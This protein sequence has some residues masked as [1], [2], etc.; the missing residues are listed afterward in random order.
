[1]LL[2]GKTTKGYAAK[3]HYLKQT[4]KIDVE[5]EKAT[6]EMEPPKEEES[7]D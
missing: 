7:A 6:T 1:L 4:P 3:G 5:Q 2:F